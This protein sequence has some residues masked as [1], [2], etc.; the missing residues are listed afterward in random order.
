M[1]VTSPK[2]KK[3]TNNNSYKRT[4]FNVLESEHAW[5]IEVYAV[6]LSREDIMLE[7][8]KDRKIKISSHNNQ[9][10]SQATILKREFDPQNIGLELLIPP[11]SNA[12]EITANIKNG[13]LNITI[14]KMKPKTI[15][16]L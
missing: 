16:I 1:I 14:P 9:D 6:G 7:L 15:S 10:K 12:E 3:E 4:P 11:K 13:I 5:H 8:N 2:I